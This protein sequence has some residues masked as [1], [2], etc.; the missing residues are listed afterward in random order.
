MVLPTFTYRIEGRRVQ[1]LLLKGFGESYEDAYDVSHQITFV[2]N[3]SYFVGRIWG[4]PCRII[5]SL[6]SHWVFNNAL[7][8]YPP[9]WLVIKQPRSPN[10]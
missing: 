10:T 8:A 7:L 4:T 1:K 3:M 9:L 6:S 5:C 2:N